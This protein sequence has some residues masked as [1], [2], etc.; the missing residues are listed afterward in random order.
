MK[1]FL[2]LLSGL[3]FLIA[4][5]FS[6]SSLRNIYENYDEPNKEF[7]EISR[8]FTEEIS[9]PEDYSEENREVTAPKK[10]KWSKLEKINSDIYGWIYQK[11]TLDYPIV[12]G[13]DNEYYLS[14]SIKG[15]HSIAGTIFSDV[16]NGRDDKDNHLILYGHTM[17]DGSMFHILREYKN[18]EY[19]KKH[20]K[21]YIMKDNG[22][23]Y[24]CLI[25]SA[26][27]TEEND[28]YVYET[29]VDNNNKYFKTCK[30]R[31]LIKTNVCYSDGDKL[32]TL[33]TCDG[34]NTTK[35]MVV[36]AIV[37]QNT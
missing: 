11:D 20:P 10:I 34:A 1:K 2:L 16:R 25:Y 6:L 29:E 18:Q 24:E 23:V 3:T 7:L 36:Q 19:F 13:V 5:I 30:R 31:S 9:E 28:S 27:V 4:G 26:F 37:K 12:E 8:N 15:E 21:F 32:I 14:H 33:S 35:R 22:D 17:K